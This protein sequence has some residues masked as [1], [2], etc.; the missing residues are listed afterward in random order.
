MITLNQ[1]NRKIVVTFTSNKSINAVINMTRN[2]IEPRIDTA[3]NNE[4]GADITNLVIEHGLADRYITD[5]G[6]NT[7]G[8]YPKTF[9]SG[10]FNGTINQFKTRVDALIEQEKILLGDEV[11][12]FGGTIILDGFHVH[13]STGSSNEN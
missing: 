12:A 2:K 4:F 6:N 1:F 10:T 5:Q 9:V 13:R 11:S 3:I 7:F 8:I